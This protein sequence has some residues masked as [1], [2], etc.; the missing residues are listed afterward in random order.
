M[1]MPLPRGLYLQQGIAT[2]ELCIF[3]L[4]M[5]RQKLYLDQSMGNLRYNANPQIAQGWDELLL[6][7]LKIQA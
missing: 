7:P 4:V 5:W 6:R 3:V 2:P 1:S